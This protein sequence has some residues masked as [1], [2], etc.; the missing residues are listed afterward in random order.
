MLDSNGLVE[1]RYFD[2]FSQYSILFNH[3]NNQLSTSF[4]FLWAKFGSEPTQNMQQISFG[5]FI[6]WE[7]SVYFC[8]LLVLSKALLMTDPKTNSAVF[9][10]IQCLFRLLLDPWFIQDGLRLWAFQIEG[11]NLYLRASAKREAELTSSWENS[12]KNWVSR[13]WTK[14]YSKKNSK[15]LPHSKSTQK[16]RCTL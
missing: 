1:D 10:C 13:K 2:L 11:F 3:T 16:R 6:E 4:D 8:P 9:P 15:K 14:K 12:I 5:G 7:T